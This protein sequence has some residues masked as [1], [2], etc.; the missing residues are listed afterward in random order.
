MPTFKQICPLFLRIC[1]PEYVDMPFWGFSYSITIIPSWEYFSL[2][3]IGYGWIVSYFVSWLLY[4]RP[5]S[6]GHMGTSL[7][8]CWKLLPICD[9]PIHFL[10]I[11]DFLCV[12]YMHLK[13]DVCYLSVLSKPF[14]DIFWWRPTWI[15]FK[16]VSPWFSVEI[17]DLFKVCVYLIVNN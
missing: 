6:W 8:H 5:S 11:S 1:L 7:C 9:F 15:F 17:L 14:K 10:I 2:N 3:F 16:G 13:T 4:V 12:I